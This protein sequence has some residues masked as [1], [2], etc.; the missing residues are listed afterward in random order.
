MTSRL[1]GFGNRFIR[2]K[3]LVKEAVEKDWYVFVNCVLFGVKEQAINYQVGW[4][5]QSEGCISLYSL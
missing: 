2:L 4:F 1:S 3:D 5:C